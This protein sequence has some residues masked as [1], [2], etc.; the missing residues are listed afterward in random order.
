M[1]VGASAAV[2]S[3]VG[4]LGSNYLPSKRKNRVMST[5]GGGTP[6]GFVAGI[7]SGVTI[8]SDLVYKICNLHALSAVSKDIQSAAAG[9]FNTSLN[10]ASAIG[11]ATSATIVSSVVPDQ[12][13]ATKEEL[14][15]GYHAAFY[16]AVGISVIGLIACVFLKV[17][18]TK[19]HITHESRGDEKYLQKN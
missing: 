4:I 10:I 18:T 6:I 5:F 7:I 11:L 3:T 9:V 17:G 13:N 16:F 15:K 19:E 12:V 2:P 8:G 14:L 1:G